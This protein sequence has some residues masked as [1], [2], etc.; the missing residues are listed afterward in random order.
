MTVEL[1]LVGGILS[2]FV[3]TC[4]AVYR[5]TSKYKVAQFKAEGTEAV[6]KKILEVVEERE[7][8]RKEYDALRQEHGRLSSSE[9]VPPL[10]K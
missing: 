7:A 10:S 9:D 2:V 6:N 5:L 8:I 1:L 4:Y 3:G